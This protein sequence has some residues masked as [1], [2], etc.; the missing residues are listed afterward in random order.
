[1]RT[2]LHGRRPFTATRRDQMRL[3]GAGLPRTGTLTQKLALEQLGFGPSYHWVNVIADLDQVQLWDRA[4]DGEAVWDEV[5]A[6]YDSTVD[7]PGGYFYRELSEAY[8]E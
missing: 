3:I 1:M 4:L 2:S 7:W 5:F 8:P 6:G